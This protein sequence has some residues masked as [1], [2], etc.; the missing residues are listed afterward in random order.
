MKTILMSKDAWN[1]IRNKLEKGQADTITVDKLLSK[2][3]SVKSK[4]T[5]QGCVTSM[6][7]FGLIDE[8]G[9]LTNRGIEWSNCSTY[10]NACSQIIKDIYPNE[11]I[12]LLL[13]KNLENQEKADVL[14]QYGSFGK[15]GA[16]KNVRFFY[17]L[18]NG[19]GLESSRQNDSGTIA[20]GNYAYPEAIST[21]HETITAKP[22]NEDQFISIVIN[23]SI[24]LH[25]VESTLRAITDT[26]PGARIEITVEP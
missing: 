17:T 16:I 23:A 9:N 5:A 2:I 13:D 11:I 19:A 25:K 26:L 1:E 22:R 14:Q 21:Q 3:K 6:K 20:G 24:P 15:D 18:A 12:D 8:S 4:K 7:Y 10:A